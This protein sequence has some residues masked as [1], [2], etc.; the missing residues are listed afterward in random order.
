[1]AW[2]AAGAVGL[3]AGWAGCGRA[4]GVGLDALAVVLDGALRVGPD[5]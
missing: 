5:A 2:V 3:A 1:V 4:L